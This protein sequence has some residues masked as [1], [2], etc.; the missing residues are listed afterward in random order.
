MHIN[1]RPVWQSVNIAKCKLATDVEYIK[2]VAP[3]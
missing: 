3:N 1:E 2:H